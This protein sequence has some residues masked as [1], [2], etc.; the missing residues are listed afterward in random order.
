MKYAEEL[1]MRKANQMKEKQEQKAA[2][3]AQKNA[4]KERNKYAK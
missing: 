2:L 3:K 4:N 1:K